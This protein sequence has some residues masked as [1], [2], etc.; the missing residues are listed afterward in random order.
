MKGS[1]GILFHQTQLFILYFTLNGSYICVL[2][3]ILFTNSTYFLVPTNS[4]FSIS[5]CTTHTHKCLFLHFFLYIPHIFLFSSSTQP[6]RFV[7]HTL[8]RIHVSACFFISFCIFHIFSCSPF[9]LYDMMRILQGHLSF[10]G[11]FMCF[12]YNNKGC[13]YVCCECVPFRIIY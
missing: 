6:A 1:S 5:H 9:H 13:F 7:F 4:W 3:S 12:L 8:P 10:K 2:V 11:L